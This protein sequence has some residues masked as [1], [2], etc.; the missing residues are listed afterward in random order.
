MF[1]QH[2]LFPF[3]T[4]VHSLTLLF[5]VLS[6]T[7]HY[8]AEQHK[9]LVFSTNEAPEPFMGQVTI[10]KYF[11]HYMEE[12]LMDVSTMDILKLT[13]LTVLLLYTFSILISFLLQK[14]K[15]NIVTWYDILH[16][17]TLKRKYRY[18]THLVNIKYLYVNKPKEYPQINAV[19]NVN[20]DLS[21]LFYVGWRLAQCDR[22]Q[23]AQTLPSAVAQVWLC[24]HDALQ[25]WHF[26]GIVS[27]I[28]DYNPACKWQFP[29]ILFSLPVW[30]A[31]SLPLWCSHCF[32]V[33]LLFSN[34]RYSSDKNTKMYSRSPFISCPITSTIPLSQVN[35]YHDHTKIILCNQNEEYLLT[36]INEE[37]VSTTLRLS[38][39]LMS[40]CS[41][42]LHSRMEYALKMLLERC[43]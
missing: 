20:I 26:P 6:R 4:V 41:A 24:S 28:S 13:P 16:L 35:F 19:C 38:T 5:R 31:Y 32:S 7:V 29:F 12:N 1:F 3:Q 15:S 36:Y 2:Q 33:E 22:H 17:S 30:L 8:Y 37:R 34:C 9:C 42:D 14:L 39:L 11:A 40:G 25:W 10:L 43:S 21:S 27:A 18:C 23:E